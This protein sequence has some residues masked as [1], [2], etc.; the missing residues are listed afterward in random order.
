MGRRSAVLALPPEVRDELNARLVGNGFSDYEGLSD[1]LE[2]QGWTISKSALHRHGSAL[3]ADFDAAMSDVARTTA[4]ARAWAKSDDDERG[5]LLDA[6]ARMLQDALLRITIAMRRAEAE[7]EESNPAEAA[8]TLSQVTRALADL[9]RMSI[10][11]KKWALE[12]KGRLAA[13]MSELETEAKGGKS[14]LDPETLR[15][16]REEIYGIV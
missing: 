1:W 16:V 14:R 10:G 7:A 5:D 11:Q 2:S 8:K 6:T 15:I 3:E 4:L 13:K 12:V 9:G